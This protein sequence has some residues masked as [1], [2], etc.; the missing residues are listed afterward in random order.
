MYLP[1][2][3]FYNDLNIYD[4][5]DSEKIC[6]TANA[7]YKYTNIETKE[8][9]KTR[10]D[11]ERKSQREKCKYFEN[12]ESGIDYM[13]NNICYKNCPRGT[14]PDLNNPNSKNCICEGD[15]K[16]NP[17]TGKIECI[18]DN[19]DDIKENLCPENTCYDPYS[20]EL[21]K[22]INI[23]HG[24]KVYHGIC[25]YGI[26]QIINEINSEN[27]MKTVDSVMTP[28][29]IVLN[30][31]PAKIPK[32]VVLEENSNITYID[33][34]DC[35]EKLK[36]HYN[37]PPET[38]L[39]ILGIDSPGENGK[40]SINIFNYEIY[41]QNGTQ[42]KDLSVCNETIVTTSSKITDLEII[43]YEKAK[44]M[45]YYGYDI[46]DETSNF[47]VD[48]CSAA[49]EN[50]NDITLEDRKKYYYPNINLCNEGCQY[51]EIDY[52][53]QRIICEC[54]INYNSTNKINNDNNNKKE[55][56][57]ETYL[58]YFLS[59]INYKIVKCY[60]L[61]NDFKNYYYNGGFYIGIGTLFISIALIS[62]FCMKTIN[63]LKIDLF[64]NLPTKGKLK[65]TQKENLRH[66]SVAD[67]D[68]KNLPNNKS[69]NPPR[70]KE[71]NN[72]NNV[73]SF[74]DKNEDKDINEKHHH[75]RHHK[76]H[77]IK[78]KS[79]KFSIVEDLKNDN[80]Y[81]DNIENENIS[82][83]E[84]NEKE[85]NN[86][87]EIINSINNETK[88]SKNNKRKTHKDLS[89]KKNS[90]S[91]KELILNG[92]ENTEISPNREKKEDNDDLDIDFNF[93]HLIYINDEDI[94]ESELND[95]PYQQALRIDDRDCLKIYLSV[96]LD[97]VG[98]LNLFFYR[99][100][101]TYLS[102]TFNVYLF[103]LLLDL[104]LNCFL[105]TDEVVSEK[106]HNN[107]NLSMITSFTLSII[108]NIISSIIVSIIAN[109]TDYSFLLDAILVYVKYKDKYVEN[110]ARL[111]KNI[112][113]RLSIFYTLQIMFIIAMTYYLFLFC[114]VYHYS[115][116]SIAIN[117]IIGALTSLA[118][119]AGLTLIIT[120]FRILSIKYHYYKL[121]N[122]SRYLFNKF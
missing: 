112:R 55:E 109:L 76:S 23:N 38:K 110:I 34:G 46:Y 102:L 13:F 2:L 36:S 17:E 44:E 77:R 83:K 71:I 12:C 47:Y 20:N 56:D 106:Y 113:I 3:F 95:I 94:K 64:K 25:V 103:E 75:R 92:K 6:I 28:T 68:I 105:Y 16:I 21:N 85:E 4:C 51:S 99:S 79:K 66:K 90:I 122:T 11:C 7:E 31:Y 91:T 10:I 81:S 54:D 5:F 45:S 80:K 53:T 60:S 37:L 120:I 52:E 15:S 87:N 63:T 104:T 116:K 69:S 101:Y 70:K 114:S 59:L 96:F 67:L 98:I 14:K 115:Q 33:L 32:E 118:F 107:G 27:N 73:E 22:C 43:Q 117:Y 19:S 61:F 18:V 78:H 40:S 72:T 8:C 57:D 108:S 97:K 82:N 121:F 62:V 39:Y 50:G 49:H 119:S 84:K 1:K 24:M 58:E 29:G 65:E 74:K 35:E 30:I 41:L 100:P 88:T 111:V 42:I 93:P 48:S 26:S 86:N 9:F 89:L